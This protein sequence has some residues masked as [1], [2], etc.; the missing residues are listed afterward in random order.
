MKKSTIF[1][2]SLFTLLL[3]NGLLFV[4]KEKPQWI[5]TFYAEL[6]YPFIF[7]S[8]EWFFSSFPFSIGDCFYICLI[9]SVFIQLRQLFSKQ[10]K[11]GLLHLF[12]LVSVLFAWFQL[13]WGLNYYKTPMSQQFKTVE[14][15]SEQELIR[16]TGF[17][18]VKSNE[19]H[20]KL[21]NVDS[22][23]IEF[24]DNTTGL[25]QRMQLAYS[26]TD[27]V[28][29]VK[30]SLFSLPLSYMGFSGYL[31][32]FTLEAQINGRI[33]KINLPI[34]IAHEMAHQQGYAAENEA[35]F[36]AFLNAYNHPDLDIQYSASLFAF[37]YCYAEL[38]KAN[39]AQAKEIAQTL[40]SGIFANFATS[41]AFW[42]AH[43]NPFEPLFKKSYDNY[44]K[45]NN[46]ASGIQ[47]Y[48][49]VVSLLLQQFKVSDNF[50]PI[51]K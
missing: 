36:I 50:R 16:L 40:K 17:F 25:I 51:E 9:G 24:T 46:Q 14:K 7:N 31:N 19:L 4:A 32:P 41:T 27:N 44:L 37:R 29:K 18:A 30:V 1:L 49:Q 42:K 23:A 11:H 33:P 28:G 10:W 39:P 48:N 12:L 13:S 26:A 8:R 3:G 45:V 43:Q 47:S 2:V 20:A 15:Y 6:A 38:R 21:S 35:N 5:D 22:L 34:T